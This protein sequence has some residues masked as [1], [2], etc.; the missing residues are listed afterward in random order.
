MPSQL[1]MRRYFFAMSSGFLDFRTMLSPTLGLNASSSSAK[2]ILTL[3]PAI[4]HPANAFFSMLENSFA[5]SSY[6]MS[7]LA[8]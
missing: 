4:S 8:V 7:S 6:L 5:F 2:L 3:N 1:L